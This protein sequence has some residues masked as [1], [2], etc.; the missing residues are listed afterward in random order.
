MKNGLKIAS[1]FLGMTAAVVIVL[2]LACELMVLWGE[3][4]RKAF[5]R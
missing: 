3:F 5:Q 2:P 1:I 4:L